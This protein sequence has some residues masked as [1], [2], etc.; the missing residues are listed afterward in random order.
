MPVAGGPQNYYYYYLNF[1]LAFCKISLR[2]IAPPYTEL[3]KNGNFHLFS[4]N[5][6]SE[7]LFVCSKPKWKLFSLVSK[8]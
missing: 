3:T 2:I 7:L 5:G 1:L 4:A 6:N 8:Q